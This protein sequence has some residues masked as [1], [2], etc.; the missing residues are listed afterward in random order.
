[1][2]GNNNPGDLKFMLKTNTFILRNISFLPEF[3]IYVI[4]F[5]IMFSLLVIVFSNSWVTPLTAP[6]TITWCITPFKNQK[7]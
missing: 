2:M 5:S 4:I 6:L 3:K 1:M 7:S